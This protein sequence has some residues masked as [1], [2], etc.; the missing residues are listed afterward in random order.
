MTKSQLEAIPPR[1]HGSVSRFIQFLSS[2]V[3]EEDKRLHFVWSF[4]LTVGAQ[5]FWPMFWAFLSVFILGVAKEC[6]DSRFGSGFCFFDIIANLLGSCSALV[7]V[8]ILPG[9]LFTP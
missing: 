6:W 3:E 9:S 5:L 2:K 8:S 4:W 1:M 7:F